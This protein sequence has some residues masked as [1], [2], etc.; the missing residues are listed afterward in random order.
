MIEK[1]YIASVSLENGT[2]ECRVVVELTKDG[3]VVAWLAPPD[4]DGTP[5]KQ[6]LG[7]AQSKTSPEREFRAGEIFSNYYGE[8]VVL[9]RTCLLETGENEYVFLNG[10]YVGTTALFV[11]QGKVT[12]A[13]LDRHFGKDFFKPVLKD[14]AGKTTD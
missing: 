6:C 10:N 12:Q 3:R 5:L 11:I 14:R 4:F 8:L 13:K 2:L 7:A 9:C 1:A